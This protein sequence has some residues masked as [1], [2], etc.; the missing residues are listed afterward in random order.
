MIFTIL[1]LLLQQALKVT[2]K[3]HPTCYK[4]NGEIEELNKTVT[5]KA[6]TLYTGKEY[7]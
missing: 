6:I 4:L 7:S 3:K 1:F 2:M 5:D